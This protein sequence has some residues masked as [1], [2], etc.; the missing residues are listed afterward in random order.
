[1]YDLTAPVIFLIQQEKRQVTHFL[2]TVTD[3]L[4]VIE[5]FYELSTTLGFRAWEQA[6]CAFSK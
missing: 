1:M 2:V 6:I 5:S 3:T 4:T